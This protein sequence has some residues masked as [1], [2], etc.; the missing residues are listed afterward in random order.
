MKSV[1]LGLLVSL[2]VSSSFAVPVEDYVQILKDVPMSYEPAGAICEQVAREE[3]KQEFSENQFDIVTGI[4]YGEKGRTLG[5]LDVIVFNRTTNMAVRISE[6]KCWKDLNAALAKA[7]NQRTR[8]I[9][10]I[11]RSKNLLMVGNGRSYNPQQ[12][13]DSNLTFTT[14]SQAGGLDFGFDYALEHDL[15]QLMYLRGLMLRCQSD[16]ICAK[17]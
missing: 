11:R 15:H 9:N 12:F 2:F 14:I 8:F 6:V 13:R 3:M 1:V 10:N 16:G 17:P 5:E 7:L 4:A